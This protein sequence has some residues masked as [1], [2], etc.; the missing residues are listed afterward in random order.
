MASDTGQW[1]PS[2]AQRRCVQDVAAAFG[3]TLPEMLARD[4]RL[5][6]V[7]GRFAAAW[8][9][10]QRWPTLSYPQIARML[11]YSEHSTVT[12]ALRGAEQRRLRDAGFKA[13]L[14][15]LLSGADIRPLAEPRGR[16]VRA[17]DSTEAPPPLPARRVKPKNAFGA[18]DSDARRR[19]RGSMRLLEALRREHP[20][21]FTKEPI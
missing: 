13:V 17:S 11:G 8:L 7:R 16:A 19:Q 15:A 18:A 5:A 1:Q 4:R 12:Y 21:R 3:L 14:D 10:R 2:A 6:I 20:E 9:L